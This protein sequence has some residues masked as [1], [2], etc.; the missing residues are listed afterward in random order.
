M[1]TKTCKPF[2]EQSHTS[3]E[4]ISVILGNHKLNCVYSSALSVVLRCQPA[5]IDGTH[6]ASRG[7]GPC[8]V[9]SHLTGMMFSPAPPLRDPG[10]EMMYS[11][12]G[13]FHSYLFAAYGSSKL[14]HALCTTWSYWTSGAVDIANDDG[15]RERGGEGEGE[16][17]RW[18]APVFP[19]ADTQRSLRL[20]MP[21]QNTRRCLLCELPLLS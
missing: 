16:G 9:I 3:L 18:R 4:L 20:Q 6:P 2:T 1:W 10:A 5:V 14:S 8:P 19:T 15:E 13:L 7:R 11:V 17:G 12:C 21:L